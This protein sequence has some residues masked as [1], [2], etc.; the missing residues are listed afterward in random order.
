MQKSL[1][2]IA[3]MRSFSRRASCP[4]PRPTLRGKK[5]GKASS[6]GGSQDTIFVEDEPQQQ[7]HQEEREGAGLVAKLGSSRVNNIFTHLRKVGCMHGRAPLLEHHLALTQ[8][9]DTVA[10]E[11]G[12][13]SFLKVFVVVGPWELTP[14]SG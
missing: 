6:D 13:P 12:A 10:P 5:S 7:Q 1:L 3:R 8:E 14:G 11:G 4:L 9:L 2:C